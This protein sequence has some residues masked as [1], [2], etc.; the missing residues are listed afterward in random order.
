[1]D[2]RLNRLIALREQATETR[3]TLLG[4][5]TTILATAADDGRE[6]LSEDEDRT[7]RELTDQIRTADTEITGCDERITEL[8][9]EI[10]R[11]RA[12]D[13]G[14]VAL[15]RAQTRVQVTEQPAT[16][17][18]GNGHSYL[19]DLIRF[20]FRMDADG[21][22]EDR[23]RNH[24]ED[25]T[26]SP[27]Y[28]DLDRVDGTGGFFVPPIWLMN[29]FI[30][31]ARAGR[32]VANLAESDVLPPGTDSINIP[33][34][35][36]GTATEPQIADNTQ[37]ADTDLTDTYVSAPV[38][39]VA[40]Q[41]DIAVQLLDQSPINFDQVIFSDL[42]ADYAAKLD[43][44]V[45]GGSGTAGQVL[46]VR[47]TA[48]IATITATPTVRSVYGA[49]A[50]AVQRVHT[51]RLQPPTVIAM[52]PR[53]WGWLLAQ[54][55]DTQRPLV[56]PQQNSPQN[57]LATL[58]AVAAEQIVGN[59]HG[60]PVITD[61]NLPITLGAG[62]NEDVILVMRA[63]DLRLYES[64]IRTRVFPSPRSATLTT[65]LQ[66][67]GYLAFTAARYPQ[68]IVEIGGL[69]PPDFGG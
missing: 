31:L 32:A 12:I 67:Y 56:L 21:T 2:E 58:G 59:L 38:R 20:S 25:V 17:V 53:R 57:A 23:L 69:T 19:Q 39:T 65:R 1:M 61:P 44:Q 28:R 41:Q 34:V 36:T 15:R 7:F 63:S 43:I 3:T 60:L 26:R 68:S 16:Y 49:I 37:I 29:Q 24:G 52:H 11:A 8:N 30:E 64:G 13:E 50:D 51:K 47:R 18:R 35:A 4:A 14:T 22:A 10:E 48:G 27:E 9:E 62:N 54:L 46:G 40:G 66:V 55:D 45:I 42:I 6:D 33:K 5:R